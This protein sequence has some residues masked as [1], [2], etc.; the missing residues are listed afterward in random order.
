MHYHHILPKDRLFT[1]EDCR[2]FTKGHYILMHSVIFRTK[3][4][5]ESESSFRSTPFMWT[6]YMCLSPFPM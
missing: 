1:W 5:Q 2:H 3:L 4:L 6:I